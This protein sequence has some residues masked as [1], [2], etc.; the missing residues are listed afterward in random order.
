MATEN[1]PELPPSRNLTGTIVVP[2]SGVVTLHGFG[3]KVRVER[4]HLEVEDG[5]GPDRRRFRLS[6]VSHGL[7]RLVCISDD[8][9][10]TLSALRWLSEVDA[11][12][13]MLDRLGKVRVVT[14]PASSSDA[15]L[16]RAQALAMQNGLGLQISRELIE[17]KLQG[18]ERVARE[19][20]H[21]ST[22]ADA[23]A[24]IRESEMVK[25]DT[26]E[27]L[28]LVESQGAMAYFC[29][30]RKVQVLW[31]R[32][33]LRRLP[34]H[35]LTVGARQSPLSGSPRL[36]VTP[37]HAILNFC[38]GLLEA[39]TRLALTTLG[40]DPMLGLGLHTDTP[41][42]DS[43]AFDVL[44]PVRPQ[45]ESWLLAWIAR[46]PLRRADFFETANGNC[47]L[48]SSL[49]SK[50][51]ETAPVWGKV[52]APWAEYVARALWASASKSK[53][54]VSLPTRLT[55]QYRREAKGSTAPS[56]VVVARPQKVCRSCGVEL[57]RNQRSHCAVCGVSI[58]RANMIEIANR[59]RLAAKTKESRARMSASQERQRK[60]KRGWLA[61]SLPA[62]LTQESYRELILPR[63]S[64]VTVPAIARTLKVSEPYAAKVRK[65]QHVPH[66]MHWQ[67]L[68]K[69]VGIKCI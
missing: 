23:I 64:S 20:L 50:L 47:R 6:R 36:A 60:A 22:T 46:E 32:A 49:C 34:E 8:G 63:L 19:Q 18:Q 14:G 9:F 41:N 35:W 3:I 40:L 53:S 56:R 10:V 43:L 13:V 61:S 27:R 16:R 28:R 59:G 67:A 62:W 42:R 68:A 33:D 30:L 17:A 65:G 54:E 57:S 44:E 25:A 24:S 38:F 48:M 12:F 31:P 4:G 39:Q 55:Q 45:I 29:A 58:S 21:D 66:P 11:S 52:I 5:I 15:R 7:K 51:S 26:F 2:R 37:F 1:V 69:L